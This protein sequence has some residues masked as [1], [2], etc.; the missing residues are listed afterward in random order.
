MVENRIRFRLNSVYVEIEVNPLKRLLSVLREDF[1]LT[2]P[3]EGC[4]KGECGACAVLVDGRLI[5]SCIYPVSMVEGC[6]VVTVEGL[7]GTA[8]YQV[9]AEC[10]EEAGA[11]QCGF[12]TPGMIMASIALLRKNPHPTDLQIKEGIAGNLCRCTG[13]NMIINAVTM[14]S[15]RGEGLW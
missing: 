14:A 8:G 11:V 2:G 4:G 13:Y 9:L 10:L 3:K 5:N 6:D 12:C 15:G 7:R 1:N